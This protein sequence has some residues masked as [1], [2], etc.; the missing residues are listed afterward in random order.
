MFAPKV[1]MPDDD[2]AGHLLEVVVG[3]EAEVAVLLLRRGVDPAALVPAEGALLVVA[4]HDV[5]AERAAQLLEPVAEAADEREVRDDR[6]RLLE[7]VAHGD[8]DENEQD[9]AEDDE[10]EW[11]E[12]DEEE[13]DEDDDDW[14]DD[15]DDDDG[16]YGDRDDY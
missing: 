14:D 1:G 2:V 16:R 12:E 7:P 15:E 6:V 10:E 13:D 4:G 8:R 11:E 9:D 5:L 3:P